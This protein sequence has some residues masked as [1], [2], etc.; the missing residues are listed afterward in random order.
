VSGIS[1]RAVTIVIPTYNRLWGLKD[2]IASIQAQDFGDWEVIVM[3]DAGTEPVADYIAGLRDS[4]IQYFR[5]EVNVG[6]ARNWTDG[7]L[8]AKSPY[9]CILMDDD[10][11]HTNFLKNR[12]DVFTKNPD[13]GMVYGPYIILDSVSNKRVVVNTRNKG[14]LGNDVIVPAMLGR[15]CFIG[16]AMYRTKNVQLVIK[17][18]ASFGLILDYPIN[19]LTVLR[20][21]L[22]GF[23]LDS[24]DFF[25][26]NH[27]DTISNTQRELANS[28][29]YHFLKKVGPLQGPNEKVRKREICNQA[30]SYSMNSPSWFRRI[31]WAVLS[32][33]HQP[34]QLS[35]YKCLAKR[36]MFR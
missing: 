11:Y 9:L 3:D 7:I 13:V 2:C 8:K 21:S 6:V 12:V 36:L 28:Q 26:R 5:Q 27:P 33:C 23:G 10:W 24:L 1:N 15:D 20:F 4:R 31:T 22:N 35:P 29:S 16:T 25:Y 17:E 34:F 19:L 18:A 30:I 14:W 32:I